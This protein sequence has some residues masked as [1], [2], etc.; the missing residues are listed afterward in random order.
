L[1][2]K[3]KLHEHLSFF[4]KREVQHFK[5]VIVIQKIQKEKEGKILLSVTIRKTR[6]IA[7]FTAKALVFSYTLFL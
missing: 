6:L 2:V 7:K 1:G 5:Q 4:H 3:Q